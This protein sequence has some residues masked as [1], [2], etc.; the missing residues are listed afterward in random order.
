M[1]T[2]KTL[3]N[4]FS[5]LYIQSELSGIGVFHRGK[6]ITDHLNNVQNKIKDLGIPEDQQASVLLRTLDENI[7]LEL[8]SC[9]DFC[10]EYDFIVKKLEDFY[11]DYNTPVSLCTSLL[12]VKQKPGQSLRDFI[13]EIRVTTMRLFPG[14]GAEEREKV[15]LMAFI[16]GLQNTKHSVILRQHSPATL[17]DAY[18]L[19]KN[20]KNTDESTLMKIECDS[21]TEVSRLSIRLEMAF[22]EIEKLQEKVLQLQRYQKKPDNPV[23]YSRII[24]H[25]CQK[26]GH[27]KKDC[28]MRFGAPLKHQSC[29]ICMRRNHSTEQCFF[30]DGKTKKVRNV[31]M[32]KS[33]E[34]IRNGS[35]KSFAM[36]DIEERG[37]PIPAELEDIS[38][39]CGDMNDVHVVNKVN[40]QQNR[41]RKTYSKEIMNWYDYISGN[42]AR[43]RKPLTK[44][45][46]DMKQEQTG[47]SRT[48]KRYAPTLISESRQEKAANKPVIPAV[49]E[50]KLRKNIFIDS[51]CECNIVDYSFLKS[52]SKVNPNTKILKTEGINLSCANGSPMKVIGYTVLNITVGQ[53]S[54]KMKFTVVESIFPNVLIG[55]RSMKQENICIVPAWDCVKIDGCSVPFVSKVK[56]A[57]LN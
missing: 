3:E 10:E 4:L 42:G 31:G 25:L 21:Q 5:K 11:G 51:G 47:H 38:S 34:W 14:K 56:P 46:N 18:Q 48:S 20:E 49:V 35:E 17:E 19:L 32:G 40:T 16:E 28:K 36:T 2:K 41:T 23:H 7:V 37:D 29:Q 15:M 50:G 13:S 44:E 30:K 27:M 52:V 26:P 12:A 9:H 45:R 6:R 1:A 8:R 55:I 39:E 57:Y 53:K 54:M 24:C 22:K 33:S 43:P